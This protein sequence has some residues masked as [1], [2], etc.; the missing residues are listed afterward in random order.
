[1][2]SVFPTALIAYYS[3]VCFV[4]TVKRTLADELFDGRRR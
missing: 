1:M 3:R 4:F 2:C